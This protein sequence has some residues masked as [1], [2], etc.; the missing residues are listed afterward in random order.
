VGQNLHHSI[1]VAYTHLLYGRFPG[2]VRLVVIGDGGRIRCTAGCVFWRPLTGLIL[3][4]ATA[5]D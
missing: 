4:S 3:S 1:H 5:T 2:K